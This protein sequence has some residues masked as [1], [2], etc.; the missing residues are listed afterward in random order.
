M[1]IPKFATSTFFLQQ[2][3]RQVVLQQLLLKV[4]KNLLQECESPFFA[5]DLVTIVK[6]SRWEYFENFAENSV[7]NKILELFGVLDTFKV[8]STLFSNKKVIFSPFFWDSIT[9]LFEFLAL[10]RT[11]LE[12]T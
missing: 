1:T 5:K 3:G 10:L 4:G 2:F 12:K 7:I 8:I 11:I 9:F 6:K